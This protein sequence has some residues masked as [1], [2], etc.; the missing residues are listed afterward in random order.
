VPSAL[1]KVLDWG[2]QGIVG[3]IQNGSLVLKDGVAYQNMT[4]NIVKMVDAVDPKTRREIKVES[5]QALKFDGGINLKTQKFEDYSLWLS[6]G[7]LWRDLRKTLPN[8]ATVQLRGSV[9]DVNSIVSQSVTGVLKDAFKGA[10]EQ[11]IGEQ[12]EG[13]FNKNKK[14]KDRDEERR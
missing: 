14:D 2:E 9:A 3:N 5:L 4:L 10:A 1:S 7:L 12:L 11:K 13:L 8:G 6:Q